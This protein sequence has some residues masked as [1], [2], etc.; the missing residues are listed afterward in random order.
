[1][2]SPA[3]LTQDATFVIAGRAALVLEALEHSIQS[4]LYQREVYPA[5]KFKKVPA[6]SLAVFKATD[7]SLGSYLQTVLEQIREWLE[8]GA[9][10]M[11]VLVLTDSRTGAVRERW[12]FNLK[13]TA[14]LEQ[15][16]TKEKRQVLAKT[17]REITGATTFMPLHDEPYDFDLHVHVHPEAVVVPAACYEVE[18]NENQQMN[19]ST[20]QKAKQ[21]AV[22][23]QIKTPAPPTPSSRPSPRAMVTAA[24][25]TFKLP[26]LDADKADES[27][28]TASPCTSG[29]F[30]ERA[31]LEPTEKVWSADKLRVGLLVG[32]IVAT[33]AAL[34]P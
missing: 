9:V 22:P 20:P 12:I 8:L 32:I 3:P 26:D 2:A 18:T 19:S 31:A 6:Y 5:H 30:E 10:Q 14:A 23:C 15:Q 17:L 34:L 13:V 21:L 1:M 27:G 33:T 16:S 4:V 25:T 24:V 28:T 7:D 29:A 11:V